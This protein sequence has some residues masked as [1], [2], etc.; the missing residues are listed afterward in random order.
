MLNEHCWTSITDVVYFNSYWRHI[1]LKLKSGFSF[2]YDNKGVVHLWFCFY[3][4]FL[5]QLYPATIKQLSCHLHIF[6]LCHQ[7]MS[8]PAG[9]YHKYLHTTYQG[10]CSHQIKWAKTEENVSNPHKCPHSAHFSRFLPACNNL[11]MPWTIHSTSAA[12]TVPYICLLQRLQIAISI[13]QWGLERAGRG[14]EEPT[15]NPSI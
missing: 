3:I 6:H 11:K 10:K 7:Y 1:F 12:D 2:W 14:W 8:H 15:V 9:G 5:L 13:W 4:C